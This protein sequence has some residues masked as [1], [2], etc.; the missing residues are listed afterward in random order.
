MRNSEAEADR[1]LRQARNDLDFVKVAL[2]EG[3]FAQACFNSHQ[4]AEKAL[5]ALAYHRGDRVVLGHSLTE[6]IARLSESFPP[7]SELTSL[8]GAL[9]QYYVPTRY[10]NALPGSAPFEVYDQVQAEKAVKGAE[11]VMTIASGA[12]GR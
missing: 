8:A 3:F 6:L 12:M 1:W 11:K 10:P 7:L 9:D 2:R 4:V 5:K